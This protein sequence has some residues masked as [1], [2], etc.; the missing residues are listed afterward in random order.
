MQEVLDESIAR[1][2]AVVCSI[3]AH[4]VH[5]GHPCTSIDEHLHGLHAA[6]L[7][8][9]IRAVLSRGV[10]AE[11]RGPSMC[12]QS[13]PAK[14]HFPCRSRLL[15]AAPRCSRYW[16]SSEWLILAARINGVQPF[17]AEINWVRFWGWCL[18]PPPWGTPLL[19]FHILLAGCSGD[20]RYCCVPPQKQLHFRGSLDLC[21][22]V[23]HPRVRSRGISPCP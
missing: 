10:G 14:T 4:R 22:S 6:V 15:M 13:P 18:D 23:E 16:Q 11:V 20:P 19:D 2:Q 5:Q 7:T 17:W 12:P 21:C 8:G 3:V 9:S 1:G